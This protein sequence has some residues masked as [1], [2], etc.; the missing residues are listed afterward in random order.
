MLPTVFIAA[1]D[2]R[3]PDIFRMFSETPCGR[4]VDYTCAGRLLLLSFT[5]AGGGGNTQYYFY[6]MRGRAIF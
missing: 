5:I 3:V 4:L 1:S 2:P 6:R